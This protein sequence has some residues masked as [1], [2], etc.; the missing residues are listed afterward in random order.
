MQQQQHTHTQQ[1]CEFK[2]C[3]IKNKQP[4]SVYRSDTQLHN[5]QK[6]NLYNFK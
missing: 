1:C 4:E 6:Q 3:L 5:Q 2:M